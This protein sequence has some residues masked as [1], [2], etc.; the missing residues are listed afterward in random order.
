MSKLVYLARCPSLFRF[1]TKS[2]C[3]MS[4]PAITG[5]IPSVDC[6]PQLAAV[7]A[8][9]CCFFFRMITDFF[10]LLAAPATASLIKAGVD[11][12]ERREKREQGREEREKREERE[13]RI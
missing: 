1:E 5:T 3:K 10:N 12:R 8:S 2:K 13:E 11:R 9:C 7:A 6:W 4:S